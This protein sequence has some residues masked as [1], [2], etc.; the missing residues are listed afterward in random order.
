[1]RSPPASRGRYFRFCSSVPYFTMGPAM[2]EFCTD[3]A[4]PVDAHARLISSST[5]ASARLPS[6]VPPYSSGTRKPRKPMSAMAFQFSQAGRSSRSTRAAAGASTPS[7]NSRAVFWRSWRSSSSTPGWIATSGTGLRGPLRVVVEASPRL[8]PE[9]SGIHHAPDQG[10]GPVLGVAEAPVEDLEDLEADVEADQV[11]ELE[12]PH[13]VPHAEPEDRVDVLAGGD[14]FHQRE[15]RLVDEG[16]EDPVRDE[17]GVVGDGDRGLFEPPR[18]LDGQ[19]VNGI[20]GGLAP[21]DLHELHHRDGVHE[22]HAYDAVRAAR[23]RRELRDRDRG[24][25]RGEDDIG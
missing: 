21:D 4:T 14:A 13:R 10:T 22:V 24:R 16:H 17:P 15:G 11:R 7:A 25:V 18:E 23:R 6:P 1:M 19:R 20:G 3:T 12:R 2:S 8:P 5:T 9:V